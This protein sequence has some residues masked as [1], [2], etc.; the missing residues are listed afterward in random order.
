MVTSNVLGQEV[1][2]IG[3]G[4]NTEPVALSP[5]AVGPSG[6]SIT[7]N[8][9]GLVSDPT[10]EQAARR[11]DRRLAD[12]DVRVSVDGLGVEPRLDLEV[13]G[14]LYDG[15]GS[16]KRV[17]LRS[18]LNYP[19]F[20]I[21]ADVR[22]I[23]LST[24]GGPQTVLIREIAPN[25]EVTVEVPEGGELVVV[26]R[27][28]DAA[29]RYDE[30]APLP[31][32][33]P[34]DQPRTED[35]E[36]GTDRKVRQRIPVHGGAVTVS[37]TGVAPG[38]SV[39]TLGEVVSADSAGN[40]VLQRILPPGAHGIEVQMHGTGQEAGLVRE[41]EIP[42]SEWFTVGIVDL[43]LGRREIAGA[44][45]S[46]NRGRLAFYTDGRIANG[47]RITAS[48]DTGEEEF[49]DLFRRFD[50]KDPQSLLDRLDPAELYPTYGDDSNLEDRTPSSG[51]V[52]LRIEQDGNYL[53]YGDF[54]ARLSGNS[55]VQNERSLYGLE[56][57]WATESQTS[58]GEPRGQALTYAAQP[59][60]LPQR[61]TFLGTGGSVYFLERQAITPSTEILSVQL[62]DPDT[63]RIVETR[64]LAAGEDYSINYVQGIVT[65]DGPLQS[66]TV[67]RL[68]GGDA[69]DVV[70]V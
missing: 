48:A 46:W 56:A 14:S 39:R 3:L 29:G 47:T 24:P 26:H 51:T 33:Y 7:V 65:L 20:V 58:F 41:V 16:T 34:R 35:V 1:Q 4:A 19:A 13:S 61:D 49:E 30:T 43:T 9:E 68:G 6:F 37:G 59:D 53:Q 12:A 11:A 10:V 42:H 54:S 67:R 17:I 66:S 60:Q 52:F 70:L 8:G 15:N 57:Y 28:Y 55:L 27:V 22:V 40:F 63:G 50:E 44:G 25:G 2:K 18:A 45:T 36:A 23:D 21:R 5:E 31:L 69:L 38:A 64:Y 32:G 62:R